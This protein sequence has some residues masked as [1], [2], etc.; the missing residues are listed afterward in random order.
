MHDL[1][2]SIETVILGPERKSRVITEKE[3]KITA[4]HEAGHALVAHLLP[5][6]DPVQKIS[7]ISR[8]QAG[9][10][11]LKVPIEDRSLHTKSEFID[12][13]S[14]LLAGHITEKE[15]F[16]DVTTGASSDLKRATEIAR[17]LVTAY[18]MSDELGLRT[19]GSDDDNVFLGQEMNNKKDYSEKTSEKIDAA[20]S[21][22]IKESTKKAGEIVRDQKK[23]LDKVAQALLEKETLEKEEFE[24]IV[25]KKKGLE[26]KSRD[27]KDESREK[28]DKE[29]SKV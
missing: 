1:F 18:G 3:K 17:K 12:E 2:D 5:N 8:G 6:S 27:D 25:G 10:Y 11:T 4:Y 7:I 23:L 16:K 26:E 29:T 15:I 19:F 14:V 21:E 24:S 13:L 20:V 9:G 28:E 22:L